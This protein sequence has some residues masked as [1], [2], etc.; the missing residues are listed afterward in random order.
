MLDLFSRHQTK[1]HGDAN[2]R[3]LFNQGVSREREMF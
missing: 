3:L 2:E 1:P